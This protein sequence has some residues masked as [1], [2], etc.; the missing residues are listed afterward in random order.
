VVILM[1]MC[2]CDD[3]CICDYCDDS[4]ICDYCDDFCKFVIHVE[5]MSREKENNRNET[6]RKKRKNIKK[7]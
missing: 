6:K 2:L 3:S 7:K 4:C 1:N 5:K